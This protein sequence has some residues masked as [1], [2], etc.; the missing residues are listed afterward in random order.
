MDSETRGDEREE[1]R[2]EENKIECRKVERREEFCT[3]DREN[4]WISK[5]FG[6]NC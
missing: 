3:L 1:D 2:I 4:N 5:R 6:R